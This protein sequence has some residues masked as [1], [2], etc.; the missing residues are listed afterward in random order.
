MNKWK[1]FGLIVKPQ[2][3]INW[4]KS[5]AM[6]PTPHKV[7]NGVFKIFFGARNENNQS[8]VSYAVVDLTRSHNPLIEISTKPVLSPGRLGTFDD[9]GVLPSCFIEKDG[10]NLLYTIGFKPGGTTR[11]DLFGGLAISE[12]EDKFERWSE[13]PIIERNRV[14]PLINTAPWVVKIDS[15]Y[16]MYYVSGIEWV[17][18]DL[19]RYNIQIAQSADAINWER[20][21]LVAVDLLPNED[22]L[23]RP[24]VVSE[25]GLFKMWFSSKGSSYSPQ[26]ATSENGKDWIRQNNEFTFPSRTRGL[27]DEM[28]CYPIALKHNDQNFLLYNGNGYGHDGI[29]LAIQD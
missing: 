5:H 12:N 25:N 17:S 16:L 19:P 13:A 11:M 22:A 6:V 28:M 7:G 9:N 24:Y 20:N 15:N 2:Q 8:L 29:C 18:A 27:D 3:K 4:W 21:G 1:K 10:Q 26:Y 14:N 23:A